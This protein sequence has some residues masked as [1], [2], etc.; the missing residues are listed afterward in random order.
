MDLEIVKKFG[1][2]AAYRDFL[3]E[4]I[5]DGAEI[6][7]GKTNGEKSKE[8]KKQDKI[9][10]E[11][12]K[13]ADGSS[14]ETHYDTDG[15]EQEA[16]PPPPPGPPVDPTGAPGSQISVGKKSTDDNEADADKA[17]N[18]SLSGQKE[19]LNLKPKIEVRGYGTKR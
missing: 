18:I 2:L 13:K 11:V 6:S 9:S 7:R 15:E 3:T 12:E 19:K 8:E 17:V 4:K 1:S 16:P 10:K 14:T 5:N